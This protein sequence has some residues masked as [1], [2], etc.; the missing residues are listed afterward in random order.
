MYLLINLSLFNHLNL[1]F[2]LLYIRFVPFYDAFLC[3]SLNVWMIPCLS[4]FAQ[5]EIE[6]EFTFLSYNQTYIICSY[7][8]YIM[9]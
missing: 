5:F 1:C 8:I 9:Y 3:I 4:R 2:I 6:K 7:I